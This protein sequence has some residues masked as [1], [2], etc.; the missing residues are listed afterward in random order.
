MRLRAPPASAA[1]RAGEESD[2]H[3]AENA[4]LLAT[5]SDHTG[6]LERLAE[7]QAALRR[8]ATLVADQA[9]ADD[10]FTAVAEEVTRLLRANMGGVARY[11]ADQSL[12]LVA[13]W[14]R[15]SR[16]LPIGMRLELGNDI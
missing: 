12:T 13:E 5:L 1:A 6:M 15:G 10:I 2:R 8:V 9:G 16:G 11:G 3:A 4:R 7:E 14:H